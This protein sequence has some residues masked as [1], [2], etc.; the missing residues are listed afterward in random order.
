VEWHEV[1]SSAISRVGYDSH[2]MTLAVEWRSAGL[3]H[4]FEVSEAT[5]SEL[6]NAASVGNFVSTVIKPNHRYSKA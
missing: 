4:Y 5:F 6:K 3:Y 2:S 1:S